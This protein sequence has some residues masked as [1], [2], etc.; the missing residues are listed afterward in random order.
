MSLVK[1]IELRLVSPLTPSHPRPFDFSSEEMLLVDK[2]VDDLIKKG[3]VI[4]VS[5]CANQF[6]SNIFL[7]PKKN[8]KLR[9]IINLNGL[10]LHLEKIHF[11]M[12]HL[13]S[14]LPL[15]SPGAGMTSIDLT[16]A[17]FSLPIAQ[18]SRKYLRFQWRDMLLECQ[19]LCF[20]LSLAPYYFTKVIKPVFSQLR[21]EGIPCT[22][23]LDDSLH[24]SHS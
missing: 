6:I 15:I 22:F 5:P 24:L 8:G 14:I 16:D 23:H 7:P 4:Q 2:E 21:K 19:C 20:G 1:G 10:N 12:E 3:A 18:N 11:K 9:P 17:Y 13:P